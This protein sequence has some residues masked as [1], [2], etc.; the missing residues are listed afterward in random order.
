MTRNARNAG[1]FA[2]GVLIAWAA[3]VLPAIANAANP[4]ADAR[5]ATRLLKGDNGSCSAVAVAPDVVLTAK[6]CTVLSNMHVDGKPV[7]QI[8]VH[9]TADVAF[10]SV[11][12][13]ACPC[14]PIGAVR[15]QM[16][17]GL[18]AV[19]WLYG[20]FIVTSR[21]EY[22]G[23]AVNP[24][25]GQSYGIFMGSVGPG[26]SGGGVFRV[27]V[28]GEIALIGILSSMASTGAPALYVEVST[29]SDV[30]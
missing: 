8:I 20:D 17:E 12:G 27:F 25:D 10:L 9:K 26:M 3:L 13:L 14:V 7:A 15:P 16:D 23:Q 11:P 1:W 5:A 22:V 30:W 2:V 6:H 18:V 28:T 24:E 19:G 21:G 4:F 29:D